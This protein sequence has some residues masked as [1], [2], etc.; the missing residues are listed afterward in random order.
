MKK[1][2]NSCLL[3]TEINDKYSKKAEAIT[4]KIFK[5]VI[6]IRKSNKYFP[7]FNGNKYKNY[8][9][10]FS[11]KT[12]IIFKKKFIDNTKIAAINFHTSLPRYP[13]SGGVAWSLYNKD[14]DYGVT[15]HFLNQKIDQGKI[16]LVK[17]YPM[18]ENYN[19]TTLQKKTSENHLSLFY[20][21]LKKIS[22]EGPEWLNKTSSGNTYR[23]SNK[24]YR[25]SELNELR[26]IEKKTNKE[27]IDLI[28]K[29]TK[30]KKHDI[31]FVDNKYNIT[32]ETGAIIQPSFFPW[33]GFFHI[34]SRVE[35]FIFLDHVQF[36]K[37]FGARNVI[38]SKNQ[39]FYINF[40]LKKDSRDK[41]FNERYFLNFKQSLNDLKKQLEFSYSKAKNYNDLKNLFK[42]E[43]NFDNIA[44]FNI[45]MIKRI[46]NYLNLGTKFFRSSNIIHENKQRSDL[47]SHICNL[48]N[49]KKYLSPIGS[50]EYMEK[51]N[52]GKIFKGEFKFSS[53]ESRPYFQ[54]GE[55]FLSYLS[56]LDLIAHNDQRAAKE[57]VYA[58]NIKYW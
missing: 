51:D 48:Y 38:L 10:L 45:F 15:C 56:I 8:D 31:K 17:K 49:I 6:I 14:E 36:Q 13:G 29:S 34:I 43:E 1:I 32:P 30:F 46:S 27:E 28:T 16:I 3:F 42:F 47:L 9:Y 21:V 54:T 50:K 44:D 12:K 7:K 23:W 37:D 25:I 5:K 18:E 40:Q 52:F 53:F 41:S 33:A 19:L 4:K 58:R 11:F 26:K 39:S 22:S 57:Y 24:T 2:N 55:K 20:L 35:K